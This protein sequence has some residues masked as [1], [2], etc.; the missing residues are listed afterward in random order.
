MV[1]EYG[2]SSPNINTYTT[3]RE[4]FYREVKICGHAHV[5]KADERATGLL[6]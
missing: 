3:W 6:Q 4:C 5:S 1:K 2:F